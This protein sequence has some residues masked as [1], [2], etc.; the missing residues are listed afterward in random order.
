MRVGPRHVSMWQP[1]RDSPPW[2]VESKRSA[3]SLIGGRRL[4]TAWDNSCCSAGR[5]ELANPVWSRCSPHSWQVRRTLGS[6][7][8]TSQAQHSA[9]YPVIAHLERALA[10]VRDDT[11]DAKLHKLEAALAQ[12]TFPLPEIVP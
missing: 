4:R 7:A 1:S 9:L 11:P 8:A 6:N 10:F 2:W 3:C 12:Y 5:R